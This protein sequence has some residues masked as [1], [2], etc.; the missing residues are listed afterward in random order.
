MFRLLLVVAATL[1]LGTAA[2]AASPL[3]KECEASLGLQLAGDWGGGA[4]ERC[5]DLALNHA[6]RSG[7]GSVGG[8]VE[9][10]VVAG[11]EEVMNRFRFSIEGDDPGQPVFS[12]QLCLNW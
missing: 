8:W 6:G 5:F 11:L 1:V 2:E 7:G 3:S 4:D 12:F 9:H 10:P